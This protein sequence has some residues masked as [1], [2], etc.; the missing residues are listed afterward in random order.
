MGIVSPGKSG[1]LTTPSRPL[2]LF[3]ISTAHN[4]RE[5]GENFF[6]VDKFVDSGRFV[7]PPPAV[8]AADVVVQLFDVR[9][10]TAGHDIP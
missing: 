10:V 6:L 5:S 3:G 7:L 8:N 2:T 4:W 1:T 9:A